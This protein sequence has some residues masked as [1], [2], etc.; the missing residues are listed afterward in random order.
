MGGNEDRLVLLPLP[1][2]DAPLSP[3]AKQR[4]KIFGDALRSFQHGDARNA[5]CYNRSDREHLLGVI[6]SGFG[7][8]GTFN[9]QLHEAFASVLQ[10]K[11]Q[12]WTRWTKME[13]AMHTRHALNGDARAKQQ[14]VKSKGSRA[15]LLSLG[16][17]SHFKEGSR[18]AGR[19]RGSVMGRGG[20][21]LGPS[22]SNIRRSLVRQFSGSSFPKVSP[23]PR[24]AFHR[25]NSDLVRGSPPLVA[26]KP[27]ASS[28][29]LLEPEPTCKNSTG[30]G[31]G[32]GQRTSSLSAEGS[33]SARSQTLRRTGTRAR[34]ADSAVSTSEP[35]IASAAAAVLPPVTACPAAAAGTA[36]DGGGRRARV[37][38]VG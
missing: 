3:D 23:N 27:S 4:K 32:T 11:I 14:Q 36:Q 33:E 7:S 37:A 34:F 8:I 16:S 20:N 9:T 28:S 6:E 31:T 29:K 25:T 26:T 10:S 38:D 22:M 18:V 13:V 12:A 1:P 5:G 24:D 19:R 21:S 17:R 30:T 35:R 2:A 15:N